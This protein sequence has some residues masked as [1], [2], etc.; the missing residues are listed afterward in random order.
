[1]V[2]KVRYMIK[3]GDVPL[4]LRWK[5]ST[6]KLSWFCLLGGVLAGR[7]VAMDETR[8]AIRSDSVMIW[9]FEMS[10]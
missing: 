6:R 10:G 3:S 4:Y 9:R 2:H 1:M 7:D 5:G 8:P